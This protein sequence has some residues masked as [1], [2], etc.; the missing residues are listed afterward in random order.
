MTRSSAYGSSIFLGFDHL[1]RL[2]ERLS[3]AGDAYPPYDVER[4]GDDEFRIVLAVAGF[5]AEQLSATVEDRQLIIRGEQTE[6]GPRTYLHRG[7]AARRFQRGFVL[8]DGLEVVGAELARGLLT[9]VVRRRNLK[10]DVRTITIATGA[11]GGPGAGSEREP[12]PL[13]A[14]GRPERS[15]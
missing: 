9:V 1:E 8:A 7:I 3:K 6:E 15:P 2:A 14:C 11:G 13:N 4:V 5:S 12:Y 10:P